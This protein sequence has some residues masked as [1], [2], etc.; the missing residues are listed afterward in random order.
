MKRYTKIIHWTAFMLLS[1]FY[2]QIH[3]AQDE[4]SEQHPHNTA[5]YNEKRSRSNSFDSSEIPANKRCKNK[6]NTS[7]MDTVEDLP[8]ELD[9]ITEEDPVEEK[10]KLFFFEKEGEINPK[11]Q[12]IFAVR[13]A[14]YGFLNDSDIAKLSVASPLSQK[15]VLS[16]F[17]EQKRN[18]VTLSPKH[19]SDAVFKSVSKIYTKIS[20]FSVMNCSYIFDEHLNKLTNSIE[21]LEIS[22]CSNITDYGAKNI[23]ECCPNLYYLSVAGCLKLTSTSFF[24]FASTYRTLVYF[25]MSGFREVVEESIIAIINNN[26]NISYINTSK[27]S[28]VGDKTIRALA[29]TCPDLT[30][31]VTEYCPKIKTSLPYLLENCKNINLFNISNCHNINNMNDVANAFAQNASN[32]QTLSLAN[33]DNVTDDIVAILTQ[34]CQR[35]TS[36]DLTACDLLTDVS[37]LEISM[38]AKELQSFNISGCK[39]MTHVILIPLIIKGPQLS[40]LKYVNLSKGAGKGPVISVAVLEEFIKRFN[41]TTLSSNVFVRKFLGE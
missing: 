9:S 37:A 21:R 28:N 10:F 24:Y 4:E 16:D 34:Y 32:L 12:E 36:I 2:Q 38:K 7:E 11:A 17:T 39:N 18:T 33:C 40:K 13:S 1:G 27:C 6:E 25:N 14:G 30:S 3:S 26:A 35:L 23:T 20:S 5:L 19:K 31:L 22:G 15:R 8:T 41:M 29:N